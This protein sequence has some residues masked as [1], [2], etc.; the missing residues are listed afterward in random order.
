MLVVLDWLL[1]STHT[2]LVFFNVFGWIWK[3]TRVAHLIT[4]GLTAFSWFVLGAV[5]GWGYCFCTDYHARILERLGYPE[6]NLTFL[7][8]MAQRLFGWPVSSAVADAWGVVVFALIV[9][10]T[11]SVWLRPWWLAR[12]GRPAALA[13]ESKQ[14]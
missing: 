4:F 1:F 12:H 3:R 11:A 8:L 2:A 7:Q 9:M 14:T 5:Y 10:A 6:A 13:R